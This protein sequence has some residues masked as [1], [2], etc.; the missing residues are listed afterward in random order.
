MMVM[1]KVSRY[2]ILLLSRESLA[3]SSNLPI[4]EVRDCVRWR[5]NIIM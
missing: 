5:N 4:T 2:L 1:L 3:L